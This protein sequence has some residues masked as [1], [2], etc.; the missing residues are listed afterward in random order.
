MTGESMLPSFRDGDYVLLWCW[1][2]R[3][4]VGQC[5]VVDHPDFGIIIKRVKQVNADLSLVLHGDNAKHS[6]NSE[7]LGRLEKNAV[8]GL[9]IGK[10]GCP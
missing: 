3:F 8:V 6:T 4:R 5:V 10:V 7:R 2:K 9:V 1:P